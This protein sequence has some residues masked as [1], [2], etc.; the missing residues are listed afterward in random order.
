MRPKTGSSFGTPLPAHPPCLSAGADR[1]RSA[2]RIARPPR[3]PPPQTG[4]PQAKRTGQGPTVDQGTSICRPCTPIPRPGTPLTRQK[5]PAVR[6]GAITTKN[7]LSNEAK[8][9]RAAGEAGK[10]RAL[11]AA[12]AKTGRVH[13]TNCVE[14]PSPLL[15]QTAQRYPKAIG[16]LLQRDAEPMAAFREQDSKQIDEAATRGPARAENLG[17]AKLS[18]RLLAFV[19]AGGARIHPGAQANDYHKQKREGKRAKLTTWSNGQAAPEAGAVGQPTPPGPSPAFKAEVLRGVA[20]AGER[21]T[22]ATVTS[23]WAGGKSVST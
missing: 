19:K 3:P 12:C 5:C 8:T 13:R 9:Y 6:P 14:R 4:Q 21:A 1:G 16:E 11:M 22:F 18:P 15:V 2:E 23:T 20:K 10:S 7:Y 17:S